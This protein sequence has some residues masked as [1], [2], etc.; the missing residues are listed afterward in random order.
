MPQLL[1]LND[2]ASIRSEFESS[3][4]R[5]VNLA[6]FIFYCVISYCSLPETRFKGDY[7]SMGRVLDVPEKLPHS[8]TL[9]ATK[10]F[11]VARLYYLNYMPINV[12]PSVV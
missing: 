3:S 10:S 4:L 11:S 7:L 2:T 5:P 8:H 1:L 9:Y 6:V 12:L